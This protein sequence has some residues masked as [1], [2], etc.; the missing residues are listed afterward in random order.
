M[1]K[2]PTFKPKTP[3]TDEEWVHQLRK[4]TSQGLNLSQTGLLIRAIRNGII[5]WQMD[6]T[7]EKYPQKGIE[8]GHVLTIQEEVDL[9]RAIYNAVRSL[10][11]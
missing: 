1:P 9:E 8:E 6:W 7:E 4:M 5:N 3:L 2:K 10:V 11:W